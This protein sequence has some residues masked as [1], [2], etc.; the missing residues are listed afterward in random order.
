MHVEL[1]GT[2]CLETRLLLLRLL[3]TAAYVMAPL[4]AL[5]VMTA[6]NPLLL[7]VLVLVLL[8]LAALKRAAPAACYSMRRKVPSQQLLLHCGIACV[9]LGAAGSTAR[10]NNNKVYCL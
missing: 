8:L 6:A 1:V 5:K 3:A 9:L 2:R 10:E 7:M 4:L